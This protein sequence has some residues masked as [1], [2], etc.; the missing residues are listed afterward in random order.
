MIYESCISVVYGWIMKLFLVDYVNAA[1]VDVGV[2]DITVIV[3]I[4]QDIL[5]IVFN[6]DKGF[7]SPALLQFWEMIKGW[8]FIVSFLP[9]QYWKT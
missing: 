8:K 2:T 4:V 5:I 3:L 6:H 1:S 7:I 9:A